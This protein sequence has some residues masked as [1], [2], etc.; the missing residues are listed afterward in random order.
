MNTE[1]TNVIEG[2]SLSGT[3]SQR[4]QK[5]IGEDKKEVVTYLVSTSSGYYFL[6]EFLPQSYYRVGDQISVPV[7]CRAFA[8]KNNRLGVSFTIRKDY[9]ITLSG[10]DF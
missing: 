8:R 5:F 6:D 9:G 1:N 3:V 10:E 2:L 7:N 4:S